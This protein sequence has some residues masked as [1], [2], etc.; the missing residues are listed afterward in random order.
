[1]GLPKDALKL[2]PKSR[3]E[4]WGDR[5]KLLTPSFGSVPMARG[6]LSATPS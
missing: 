4:E 2:W 5:K 6:S 3:S 1:V